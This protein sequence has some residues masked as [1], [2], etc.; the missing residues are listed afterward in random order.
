[1]RLDAQPDYSLKIT[2]EVRDRTA[3]G[4]TRGVVAAIASHESRKEVKELAGKISQD[5]LALLTYFPAATK[6]T[7]GTPKPPIESKRST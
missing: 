2:L 6:A 5:I 3:I 7:A 4:K 1:M